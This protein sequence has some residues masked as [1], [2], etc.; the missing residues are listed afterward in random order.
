MSGAMVSSI[1]YNDGDRHDDSAVCLHTPPSLSKS[2]SNI[3]KQ[4]VIKVLISEYIN[5]C[6]KTLACAVTDTRHQNTVN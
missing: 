6:Y 5:G 2:Y 4:A 1:T 3:N